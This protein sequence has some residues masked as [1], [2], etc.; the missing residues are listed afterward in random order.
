MMNWRELLLIYRNLRKIAQ[1]FD[2]NR[3]R[4]GE[5]PSAHGREPPSITSM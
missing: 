5:T 4:E 1:S 3:T 2:E